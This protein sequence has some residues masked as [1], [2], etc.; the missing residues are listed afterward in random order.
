MFWSLRWED[1]QY[2]VFL[3]CDWKRNQKENSK[4][5]KY[6]KMYRRTLVCVYVNEWMFGSILY[7]F[8]K[9]EANGN[10]CTELE[11][12]LNATH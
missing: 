11:G 6:N 9:K 4:K 12:G 7:V 8:K 3:L 2:Y 1:M 10:K 5:K